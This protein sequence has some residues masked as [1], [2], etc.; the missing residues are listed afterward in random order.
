[1][2]VLQGV[3]F[4][5]EG[6]LAAIQAIRS[7][8]NWLFWQTATP[9]GPGSKHSRNQL[10]RIANKSTPE[11]KKLQ[12]AVTARK[13]IREKAEE[14]NG[15]AAKYTY[16]DDYWVPTTLALP[17]STPTPNSTISKPRVK[18]KPT[19]KSR[20]LG[21]GGHISPMRLAIPVSVSIIATAV[22]QQ[23]VRDD[24]ASSLNE[25]IGGSMALELVNSHWMQIILTG[26]TW[27]VIGM[28]VMGVGEV[29]A[30][31]IRP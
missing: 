30:R 5:S 23:M 17:A 3:T 7:I 29:I 24:D 26:V 14:R 19:K 31:K 8:S 25:H 22:I 11:I 28:A 1:M 9:A 15:T 10:T 20:D 27:Y 12:A 2:I 4:E 18:T 16:R 13:Q 6:Q 21:D